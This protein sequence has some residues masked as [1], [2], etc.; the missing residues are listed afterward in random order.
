MKTSRIIII[1]FFTCIV[2][3]MLALFAITKNHEEYSKK[4][5]YTKEFALPEFSVVVAEQGADLHI[6]HSNGSKMTV[7]YIKD[8]KTPSKIYEVRNDTLHVY[9]GL[10]TFVRC[11]KINNIVLQKAFWVGVNRFRPDSLTIKAN[12]GQIY[13]DNN[14]IKEKSFN[15]GIIATDSAYVEIRNINGN[16]ISVN[17]NNAKVE[18]KCRVKSLTARLEHNANLKSHYNPE[19]TRIERDKTS[20]FQIWLWE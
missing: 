19:I 10:R 1:A 12:G 13:C 3:G 15:I 18:L 5:V 2:A 6:D 17:S 20:K 7:E 14:G 16:N 4:N 9:G 11:K 8:K